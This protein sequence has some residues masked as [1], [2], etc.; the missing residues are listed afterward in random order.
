[1]SLGDRIK[2]TSGE[3]E[4]IMVIPSLP[5]ETPQTPARYAI[6]GVYY[7]DGSGGMLDF[8]G[9]YD[10]TSSF[11][12]EHNVEW[13]QVMDTKTWL[14]VEVGRYEGALVNM[15][16]MNNQIQERLDKNATNS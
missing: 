15:D 14:V 13:Y 11:L 16:K 5:A 6:F 9:L 7:Y 12:Q 8:L 2:I 1:M 3:H 4:I 10:D